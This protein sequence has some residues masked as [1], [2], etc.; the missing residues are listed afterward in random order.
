[1]L[2]DFYFEPNH[3]IERSSFLPLLYWSRMEFYFKLI[4]LIERFSFLPL[5]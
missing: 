2:N 3:L 4:H 5:E 1:M